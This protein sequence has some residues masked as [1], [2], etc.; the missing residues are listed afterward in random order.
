MSEWANFQNS[1]QRCFLYSLRS[2]ECLLLV[3]FTSASSIIPLIKTKQQI[4]SAAAVFNTI[5]TRLFFTL[6]QCSECKSEISKNHAALIIEFTQI[7]WMFVV[8][9]IH[10]SF[11]HYCTHQIKTAACFCGNSIQYFFHAPKFQNRILLEMQK[12]NLQKTTVWTVIVLNCWKLL[13]ECFVSTHQQ[14]EVL[15]WHLW[16][17]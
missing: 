4:V 12:L 13:R 1:K 10:F 14:F 6:K 15:N 2:S 3:S 16:I 9:I 8:S 11:N 17:R 7:K 5:F